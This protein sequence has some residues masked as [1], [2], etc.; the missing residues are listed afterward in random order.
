MKKQLLTL[1]TLSIS[2]LGYG[3]IDTIYSNNEKI[4]C[5][6]K[7]IT[8]DAVKYSYEGEDL[9]NTIYKNTIQKIVMKSGRVQT[10]TESFLYKKV[11]NPDDFENVTITQIES[12]VKGLFRIGIVSSKAKG[13]TVFSAQEGLKERAYRKIKIQ[14]ALMGANI[15]YITNQKMEGVRYGS[16]GETNLTGTSYNNELPNF[17]DFKKLL[18]GRTK[19]VAIYKSSLVGDGASEISNLKMQKSFIITNIINENGFIII[20]AKFESSKKLLKYRVVSYTNEYFN[21]FY[22]GNGVISSFKIKL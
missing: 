6:I 11:E 2:I 7:E 19:F 18:N 21:A 15:V 12:D 22:D 10:F 13:A 3:Q 5:N 8:T 17:E 20:E 4:P 9:V 14:A 1:I 16:T